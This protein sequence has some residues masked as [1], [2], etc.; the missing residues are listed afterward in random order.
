MYSIWFLNV[1]P[2]SIW[3]PRYLYDTQSG[4]PSIFS[5][6]LTL[7]GIFFLLCSKIPDFFLLIY[8]SFSYDQSSHI[9][10]A[11]LRFSSS[12]P[13]TERS[14]AK[15]R[16]VN[17]AVSN[18]SIRSL[19]IVRNKVGDVLDPCIQPTPMLM[20]LLLTYIFDYSYNHSIVLTSSSWIFIFLNFLMRI[21][22]CTLSKA[23]FRSM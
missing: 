20:F 7:C 19:N 10:I 15:A 12:I 2:W 16:T 3:T 4:I 5:S 8:I 1:S 21:T 13:I 9:F 14:S 23:D 17:H 18:F 11:F 22:W 6:L